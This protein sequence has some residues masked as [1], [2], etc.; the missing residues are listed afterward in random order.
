MNAAMGGGEGS[1]P[2]PPPPRDLMY[3][4][5]SQLRS[6][7]NLFVFLDVEPLSICFA[8]F[9]MP[10]PIAGSGIPS[11]GGALHDKAGVLSFAD[12]HVE[13]HRWFTPLM[14]PFPTDPK[15][16]WAYHLYNWDEPDMRYLRMRS[17]DLLAESAWKP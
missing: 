6:P 9:E 4:R 11:Y 12:G 7:A 2:R 15:F 5:D 3:K 10:L 13:T 1:D 16:D 8:S 14:R 17:H